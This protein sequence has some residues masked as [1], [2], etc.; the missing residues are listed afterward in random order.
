VVEALVDDVASPIGPE[1]G[2]TRVKATKLTLDTDDAGTLLDALT[3]K[4]FPEDT[5]EGEGRARI[6]TEIL[7]LDNANADGVGLA[8]ATAA[9]HVPTP[10][11][12]A[13]PD[14]ASVNVAAYDD[15]AV[16]ISYSL[17]PIFV[18]IRRGFNATIC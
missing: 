1:V 3:R 11:D 7:A 14:A 5:D 17:H 10:A 8:F 12:H 18:E 13:L 9:Y 15:L 4:I 16:T 6:L 2:R